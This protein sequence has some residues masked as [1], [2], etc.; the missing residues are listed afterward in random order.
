MDDYLPRSARCGSASL[1]EVTRSSDGL[2]RP[3]HVLHPSCMATTA[4]PRECVHSFLTGRRPR[5]GR[6]T[7]DNR[8]ACLG[9]SSP[10]VVASSGFLR[11]IRFDVT[12]SSRCRCDRQ[13]ESIAS[14]ARPSTALREWRRVFQDANSLPV[15]VRRTLSRLRDTIIHS[16]GLERR[17]EACMGMLPAEDGTRTGFLETETLSRAERPAHHA[18]IHCHIPTTILYY[19]T[20]EGVSQRRSLNPDCQN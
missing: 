9:W 8:V 12:N 18:Y 2:H 7:V 3:P 17:C 16:A 15:T 20:P 13:E 14:G 10:S 6:G 19:C 5:R 4:H 1:V 11:S